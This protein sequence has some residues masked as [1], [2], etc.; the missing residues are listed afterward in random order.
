RP[1]HNTCG[2]R[3]LGKAP[4]PPVRTSNVG[5]TSPR[6]AMA[7]ARGASPTESID[8]PRNFNVTCNLSRCAQETPSSGA[9]SCS[10]KRKIAAST[11]SPTRTARNALTLVGSEAKLCSNR[12]TEAATHAARAAAWPPL[13]VQFPLDQ[14]QAVI[15]EEHH[16]VHENRR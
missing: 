2:R 11:S 5:A 7:S 16:S 1:V 3:K 15:A 9:R 13:L 6:W 4:R 10:I 8:A 14:R 12:V